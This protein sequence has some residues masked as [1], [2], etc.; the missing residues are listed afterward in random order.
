MG[1]RQVSE[2]SESGGAQVRQIG[3]ASTRNPHW[4]IQVCNELHRSPRREHLVTL[5][6]E[7]AAGVEPIELTTDQAI[8][9]RE[10]LDKGA[11]EYVNT[12]SQRAHAG[13][14]FLFLQQKR[15]CLHGMVRETAERALPRR[16]PR[17]AM[18]PFVMSRDV[19]P[20]RRGQTRGTRC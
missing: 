15:R 5:I 13:A 9:L 10:L 4:S 17:I 7:G 11:T 6:L 1:Q 3:Y 2:D 16:V 12:Q 19:Q 18:E 20:P 8:K 14:L